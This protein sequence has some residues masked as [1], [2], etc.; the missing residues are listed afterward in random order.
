MCAEPTLV[1]SSKS[2]RKRRHAKALLKDSKLLD[3]YPGV[4][5]KTQEKMPANLQRSST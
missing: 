2:R 5:V 3:A 1:F 4:R